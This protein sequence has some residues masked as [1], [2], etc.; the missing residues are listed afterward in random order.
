M[1]VPGAE[2]P[3]I[4]SWGLAREME[5]TVPKGQAAGYG[6]EG[7][8]PA[9]GKPAILHLSK[10]RPI[11]SGQPSTHSIPKLINSLLQEALHG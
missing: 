11:Q 2:D 5:V 3:E 1:L 9:L 8:L 4:S 7:H 10:E 6:G